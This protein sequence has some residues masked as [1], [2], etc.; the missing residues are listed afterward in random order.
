[1][2]L[3]TIHPAVQQ[4][5]TAARLTH[6]DEALLYRVLN[7]FSEEEQIFFV[8]YAKDD[9][10]LWARFVIQLKVLTEQLKNRNIEELIQ[11]FSESAIALTQ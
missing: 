2:M 8:E 4:S 3:P 5:I 9:P 11:A 7:N 10:H 6:H 1:M